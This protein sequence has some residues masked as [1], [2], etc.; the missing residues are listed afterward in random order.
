MENEL[1]LTLGRPA[2][3]GRRDPGVSVQVSSMVSHRSILL[4]S[5]VCVCA[6]S[7]DH[8]TTLGR[9]FISQDGWL[10]LETLQLHSVW[11]MS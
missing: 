6:P 4:S 10:G 11:M 5:C 2:K 7:V 9:R 3:T 8:L 1:Y